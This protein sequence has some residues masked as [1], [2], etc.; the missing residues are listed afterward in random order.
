MGCSCAVEYD[1]RYSEDVRVVGK[2]KEERIKKKIAKDRDLP[3]SA[4][5]IVE[6]EEY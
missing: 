2:A 4:I 3:E 5:E 1:V 6:I